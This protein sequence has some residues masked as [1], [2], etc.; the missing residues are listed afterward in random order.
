[1]SN[2]LA[3]SSIVFSFMTFL[4]RVLG[5]VRD[6]VAA[7]IF[8]ASPGYDAFILSFR[9]PNLMRRLFAEGAFSQAFVPVLAEYQTNKPE[10]EVKAFIN[11][12]SGNL[13]LVLGIVTVLGILGAPLLIYLFAPGFDASGPRHVLATD[14]LRLT[15]PYIFFISLTALA[16]SL[17]NTYGKFAVPAFTPVLL[18][19]SL[20]AASCVLSPRLQNPEMALAWGVLLAGLAQ[21]L[22]QI[23]FLLKIGIMPRPQINWRDPAVRKVLWLMP[24]AI[25]GAAISQI[26]LLVDSLFA[27]FLVTGSIS[28]LYYADRLMEFPLGMIGVGLSTVIL[29]SL[30]R[31]HAKGAVNE[32]AKTV[33][34]GVRCVLLIGVPAMLGLFML[35][36]PLIATMFQSSKFVEHDVLMTSQCLMAY[37]LAVLGIMLAKIFSSAF[38]A[39]QNIKTPVRISTFILVVNVLL[40]ALLI[41]LFAH[42]GLAL[43]TSLTSVL[44]ATLLYSRWRAHHGFRFQPGWHM[45]VLRVSTAGVAMV[46]LLWLVSPNIDVWLAWG[47]WER[48][49]KLT[50]I[51]SAAGA[52]YGVV[53]LGMGIKPR[54]FV[55]RTS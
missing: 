17:L 3:K 35:A 22:F 25:F 10:Q 39:T 51:I 20:I 33:D 32:V 34:W 29:P 48:I 37:A 45:F 7:F 40:N 12:I 50:G 18:N 44:N 11:H 13:A 9:I 55:L 36:G 53:L 19:I 24:P 16:G 26:T 43:A 41:N 46:V 8:G 30:A 31:Q 47:R 4:S 15:F 2:N 21:L 49:G 27:S 28:W 38:Y 52:L 23:P 42:V 54:E 6:I 1:M 14:M 5:F